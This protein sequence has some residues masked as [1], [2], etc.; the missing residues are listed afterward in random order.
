[1]ARVLPWAGAGSRGDPPRPLHAEGEKWFV[2][3]Q[4]YSPLYAK[5]ESVYH[6]HMSNEEQPREREPGDDDDVPAPP[7]FDEK[8]ELLPHADE[9]LSW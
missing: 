4:V 9:W 5:H 2:G 8:G 6:V 3:F 1:M 7:R